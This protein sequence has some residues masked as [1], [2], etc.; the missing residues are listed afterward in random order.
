MAPDPRT[1]I[2]ELEADNARLR[3]L[4]DQRD[5]PAELRH[6]LHSTLGLLRGIVRRSA[7]TRDDVASYVAHLE[8]RLDAV[9]RA[10]AAADLRGEVD[11]HGL[12]ADELLRY[13]AREGK[14]LT[15][16]GPGVLLKPRPAQ[17][18]ALA[19]HEL[20]VN[21]VEHG[22][23]EVPDGHI[24]VTW[25]VE[26][27]EADARLNLQ[28]TETGLSNLAPSARQGFGTTVLT[29]MVRHE[30][31][32]E[33]TLAH[34]PGGPRWTLRLAMPNRVGRLEPE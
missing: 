15:I 29:E 24:A 8:D 12:V 19:I 18:V 2:D 13:A 22:A 27:S 6:R 20:A 4:L 28:W 33:A 5:T 26:G 30:L 25:S 7:E 34:G 31:S 17:I 32:A 21:A 23:L 14:R 3:R 11:L 16:S 10:Q 1:R 9:V